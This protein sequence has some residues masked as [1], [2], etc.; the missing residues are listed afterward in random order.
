MAYTTQF[1]VDRADFARRQNTLGQ[2]GNGIESGIKL[3]EENR[4]RAIDEKRQKLS[5]GMKF[6]DA[7]VSAT[8]EELKEFSETGHSQGMFDKYAKNAEESRLRKIEIEDT[9]NKYKQHLMGVKVAAASVPKLTPDQKREDVLKTHQA[10]LALTAASK[11]VKL[12][13]EN[14][15]VVKVLAK[16]NADSEYISN[17]LDSFLEKS[18]GYTNDQILTQG[19]QLIKTINS[20]LGPDATGAEEVKRLASKLEFALGNMFN[21]NPT[22]FG[23]DLTGFIEQVRDTSKI[24][25]GTVVMNKQ[26]IE[27]QYGRTP[28][29]QSVEHEVTSPQNEEEVKAMSDKEL[30]AYTKKAPVKGKS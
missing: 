18:K 13:L 10:K 20:T 1:D 19:K 15:T 29:P 21:D 17:T 5:D 12:P 4:R 16:K 14:E 9:D 11:P 3:I 28:D 24:M 7:G 26:E 30:K 2:I 25:R 22:Q 27:K 6:A 23:R 8:P